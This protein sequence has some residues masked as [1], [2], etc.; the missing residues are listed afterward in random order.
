MYRQSESKPNRQLNY[1]DPITGLFHLEM[2]VLIMLYRTHLGK[3]TDHCSLDRWIED[4]GRTRSRIWN[5]QK[6]IVKE[7]RASQD[8]FETVL[9][10]Y[11]LAAMANSCG[12]G[13]IP[14]LMANLTV[15]SD[16]LAV[17]INN[18]AKHL[19]HFGIISRM[20][21]VPAEKRDV[22]HESITMFMQH[23]LTLRSFKRAVRDGDSGRILP[24]LAYFT[25]WL[26]DTKQS[27][28]AAETIHLMACLRKLWSPD[29]KK[30]WMDNCLISLSG[31]Q[32][33]FMACDEV[34]EHFVRE[35][36]EMLPA[37]VTEDT[38]KFVFDTLSPQSLFL[39]HVRRKIME[40]TG[41]PDYGFH[42]SPVERATDASIIAKKL[43]DEDICTYNPGRGSQN[44]ELKDLHNLGLEKLASGQG[45]AKYKDNRISRRGLPNDADDLELLADTT[46]YLTLN[47]ES[48]DEE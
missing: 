18:M 34:C 42:S 31:R 47:D 23:G 2:S 7:F 12:F 41:A 22:P 5:S 16:D 30:F 36:K 8:Y 46:I 20:K 15:I 32:H 1:V 24:S 39:Y 33:G 9:D 48:E 14:D 13:D 35:I 21:Q 6:E 25:I 45:I 37:N 10:G 44:T 40:E 29:Y 43:L 3:A 19:V 28:Y 27:Q 11:I 38:L 4:A 17:N 26:Q